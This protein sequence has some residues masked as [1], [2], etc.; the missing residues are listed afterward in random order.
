MRYNYFII[1]LYCSVFV[2][3]TCNHCFN[4][5][6]NRMVIILILIRMHK[7][8]HN[9]IFNNFTFLFRTTATDSQ[10]IC[11]LQKKKNE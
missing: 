5:Y 4:L 3:V 2:V 1:L 7:H 9:S 6:A 10:W 11:K 8:T